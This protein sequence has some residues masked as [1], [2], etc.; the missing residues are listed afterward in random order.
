MDINLNKDEFDYEID[1]IDYFDSEDEYWSNF[2]N[3]NIDDNL[4]ICLYCILYYF[5][6]SVNEIKGCKFFLKIKIVFDVNGL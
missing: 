3:K 1:D 5:F 4:I 2:G 6:W